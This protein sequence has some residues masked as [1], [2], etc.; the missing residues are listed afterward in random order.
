[1]VV[2][3]G[4]VRGQFVSEPDQLGVS[5]SQGL[6]VCLLKDDPGGRSIRNVHLRRQFDGAVFNDGSD[7]HA[8]EDAHSRKGSQHEASVERRQ[9][10]PPAGPS[11]RLDVQPRK[12]LVV[13]VRVDFHRLLAQAGL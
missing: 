7:A 8:L 6:T 4:Q 5:L 3:L 2:V 9:L 11:H 10:S 12:P 1:M 13:Q